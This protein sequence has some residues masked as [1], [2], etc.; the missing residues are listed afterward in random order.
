VKVGDRLTGKGQ[1]KVTAIIQHD[2]MIPPRIFFDYALEPSRT[3]APWESFRLYEQV[4][5]EVD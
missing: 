3:A 4:S 2:E 1:G 5:V